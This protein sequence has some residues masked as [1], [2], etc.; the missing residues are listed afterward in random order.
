MNLSTLYPKRP[1]WSHKGDFGTVCVIGGSELHT[2]SPIFNAMAALRAGADLAYL[3]GPRRAMD[4]AAQYSP[5]LITMPL[6]GE[7][8]MKHISRALAVCEHATACVIGGGLARNPK[9]YRAIRAFI[10]Q[11]RLPFVI[12]AEAIRA[13]GQ[14][15]KIVRGKTMVITPHADE[16][17][18]LTGELPSAI[19]H[20]REQAVQQAALRFQ[21]VILLKGNVDIISDGKKT[22]RNRTGT[23]YMT[24]GGFGDTLAG[25][26]GAF[27]ARGFDP[28]RAVHAAAYINGKA[29]EYAAKKYG[30]GTLASD[31]LSEIS[32]IISK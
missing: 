24:K 3:M 23:P 10:K 13:I 32:T 5:D 22:I 20:K 25:I 18:A 11:C 6:D 7:F 28:V 17:R 12:D 31:L 15:E 19:L 16:F 26:C 29:G 8:S 9:T 14:D 27:L 1:A 30:E 4:V 21:T 2:G